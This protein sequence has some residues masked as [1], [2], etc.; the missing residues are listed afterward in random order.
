MAAL[1]ILLAPSQVPCY[2]CVRE[3]V[4]LMAEWHS[5]GHIIATELSR[6]MGTASPPHLPLD[7]ARRIFKVL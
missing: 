3:T 7:R 6:L 2:A 5:L 4:K 1:Y